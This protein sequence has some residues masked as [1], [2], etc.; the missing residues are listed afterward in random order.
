MQATDSLRPDRS[1]RTTLVHDGP[2]GPRTQCWLRAC[3]AVW[4]DYRTVEWT[5]PS[6]IARCHGTIYQDLALDVAY[7]LLESES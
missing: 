2:C 7:R 6:V 5:A 3:R 1:T 4:G